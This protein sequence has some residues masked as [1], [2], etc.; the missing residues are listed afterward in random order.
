ML[1]RPRNHEKTLEPATINPSAPRVSLYKSSHFLFLL[2]L[3]K[4]LHS[5]RERETHRDS[6]K[7]GEVFEAKQGGDTPAGTVR[8]SQGRDRSVLRRRHP[9]Q[10]LRS[11]FGCGDKEVPEQGDP[12]GLGQ[13]DRQEVSRQGL[14]QARQFP[15]PDAHAVHLGRGFER[16]GRC[17]FASVQ[18][19]EGQCGQRDQ[20]EA[21]G[22]V[23]DWE[24]QVVLHQA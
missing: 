9:R 7:N 20:E 14:H 3:Q 13:E 5:K 6:V 10:A 19:Q 21:R 16:R 8:R 22:A 11:L 18:G 23:Q 4:S 24:E 17:G 2:L 15:A 12:Q 1:K